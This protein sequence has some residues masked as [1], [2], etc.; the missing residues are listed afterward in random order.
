MPCRTV[1]HRRW[2]C[3]YPVFSG[4][5]HRELGVWILHD[6]PRR[7]LQHTVVRDVV[8]RMQRRHSQLRR[9]NTVLHVRCGNVRHARGC[10][11]RRVRSRAVCRQRRVGILLGVPRWSLQHTVLCNVVRGVQSRYR[12]PG[13]DDT[14]F[15]VRRGDVR[16]SRRVQLHVV[17]RRVERGSGCRI[18]RPVQSRDVCCWRC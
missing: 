5:I 14:V 16:W 10:R 1:R 11:L 15:H 6:V 13:R 2:V 3:L 9:Y 8:Y 12:Q 7:Q 4:A 17:S 18:V